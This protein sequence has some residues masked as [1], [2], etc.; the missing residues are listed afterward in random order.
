MRTRNRWALTVCAL[1]ASAVWLVGASGVLHAQGKG[2]GKGGG[3]SNSAPTWTLRTSRSSPSVRV[4]HSMAYD[5]AN[6]RT[7]VF[8]GFP[9]AGT[10]HYNDT[11]V[12]DGRRW[13]EISAAVRPPVRHSAAMAYDA[14][15]GRVVMFGGRDNLADTWELDGT[16]WTE[17]HPAVSPSGR[18]HAAMAYDAAR[19]KVVMFGGAYA[20]GGQSYDLDETWTWDGQTWEQLQ[21]ATS[22][23]ARRLAKMAYDAANDRIVLFGGYMLSDPLGADDTWVWDGTD[24]TEVTP[25]VSP[26]RR[27]STA[28]AYDDRSR[29]VVLFGGG[30]NTMGYLGDTWEWDT[31]AGTWTEIQPATSPSTRG[32]TSMAF[33]SARGRTVLFGGY[34]GTGGCCL[35]NE[36]WEY[37]SAAP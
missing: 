28:M 31:A 13:T 29:R 12:W 5:A 15:R 10:V 35:F 11:W 20:S 18:Y 4:N 22:P 27:T 32:Y 24:W 6:G 33:D 25:A 21:P 3:N 9:G 30:D 8:G 19:G 23:P 37:E 1:L 17:R 14:S 36:T 16:T 2:G 26:P 7:V 34:S